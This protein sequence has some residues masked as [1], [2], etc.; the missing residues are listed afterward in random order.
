MREVIVDTETTGLEVNE[1]HRIIEI[2]AIEINNLS[3]TGK[4]FHSYINPEREIEEEAFKIHGLSNEFLSDKPKFSD[5]SEKFLD[6][7][8]DSSLVIHNAKFDLSFINNELDL[9]NKSKIKKN[10]IID[11]LEVAK[12]QNPGAHASLDAL[13]KRYNINIEHRKKHGALKDVYLLAEVY[14]ELQGGK[15]QDLNIFMNNENENKVQ[16]QF[17]KNKNISEK[18][19]G[20][21]FPPTQDELDKHNQFIKNIE[22]SI[23]KKILK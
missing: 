15:Q 16:T 6:F 22:N 5:I 1:G 18:L 3:L 10:E 8:Q 23:W 17:N 19:K 14:I 2:A 21:N 20:R 7:I 4:N 9:C 13:C 11:T 12:K